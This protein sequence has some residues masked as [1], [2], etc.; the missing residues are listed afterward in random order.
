MKTN[1][2][3][4]CLCFFLLS[5]SFFAN[6]SFGQLKAQFS[7]NIQSGCSPLVIFFQ[8]ES[9]GN[10]TSWKWDLG[11]GTITAKQNPQTT[12]SNPGV[13]TVKLIAQNSS[14][15]DSI[16]KTDYITVYA[17]P[18]ANFNASPVEGCF[19]LDVNFTNNSQAGSGTISDYLWDFG[20][21]VTS[22]TAK[23]SHTYTVSGTFDVTLKVTNN[24]GCSNTLTQSD[25]IH[26][27]D[28][29]NADFSLTS[30]NVCKKP[31]TA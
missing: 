26:I 10:P 17:N 30:L 31:A 13:Y 16:V 5:F 23:A 14:G 29:V 24:Y 22:T 25:L 11:N 18:Q 1:R 3:F 9:K 6:S 4:V 15:I 21:G 12:Y 27:E 19:P 28:G 7:S 2:T 8:D 20:D